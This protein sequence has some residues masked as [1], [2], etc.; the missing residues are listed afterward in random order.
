MKKLLLLLSLLSFN[1]YSQYSNYYNVDVNSNIN[2][3]INQNV[4]VD[5]SG[6]VNVNKTITSIDYGALAQA[7]AIRERNRLEQLKYESEAARQQALEIATNPINAFRYSQAG[8]YKLTNSDRKNLLLG[9]KKG[10]VSYVMLH[11]SLFIQVAG[12]E[13]WLT[14]ENTSENGIKTEV[15]MS[16]VFGIDFKD[17]ELKSNQDIIETHKNLPYKV[18]EVNY[19]LGSDGTPAF[20]HAKDIKRATVWGKRGYKSTLIWEDDFEKTITDNYAAVYD[21]ILYFS[22]VRYKGDKDEV[23]FEEIEG[24]RGY[25]EN[26]IDRYISA[27]A[28]IYK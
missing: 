19:D 28:F 20:L 17:N 18:G 21:G 24:R 25:F 2:A 8:N 14:F 5:V 22:K 27:Y 23:T 6:N 10:T 12:S 11:P 16:P 13:G 4:D 9:K 15:I 1:S 26:L 7:N 3:N